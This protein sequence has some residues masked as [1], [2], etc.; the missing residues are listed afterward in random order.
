[1]YTENLPLSD[2][3]DFLANQTAVPRNAFPIYLKHAECCQWFICYV[4]TNTNNSQEFGLLS[5]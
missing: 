5:G 3:T 2:V 1:M 4:E